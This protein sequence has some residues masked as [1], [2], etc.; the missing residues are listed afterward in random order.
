VDSYLFKDEAPVRR[1]FES[2]TDRNAY[3]G[4]VISE[5]FLRRMT[6]PKR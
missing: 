5:R 1:Q 3:A 2:T 4:E 6:P